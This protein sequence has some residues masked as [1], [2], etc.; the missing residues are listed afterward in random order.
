MIPAYL[1][2]EVPRWQPNSEADL[3]QAIDEGVLTEGHYLEFKQELASGSGSN[4]ELA[5]DLASLAV[6]GGLLII[7]VGEDKSTGDLY[8]TP[9]P[10]AGLAERVD[11]IAHSIPDPPIAVTIRSIPSGTAN[12]G[13]LEQRRGRNGRVQHLA[14]RRQDAPTRSCSAGGFGRHQLFEHD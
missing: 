13:Y 9:V 3:R 7:G 4:K 5:R 14:F 6:D 1:S 11:Q 12:H 10:L 8:L 2:P